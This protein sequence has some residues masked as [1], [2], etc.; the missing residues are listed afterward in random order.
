MEIN[1][2]SISACYAWWQAFNKGGRFWGGLFI[3]TQLD[4]FIAINFPPYFVH[5]P[6]SRSAVNILPVPYLVE[7]FS[8]GL[9]IWSSCKE[10]CGRLPLTLEQPTA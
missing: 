7:L 1:K 2:I 8:E 3:S 5:F 4:A 9:L 6:L 10:G